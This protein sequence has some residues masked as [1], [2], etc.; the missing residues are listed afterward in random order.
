MVVK[1][2]SPMER[3]FRNILTGKVFSRL[4]IPFEELITTLNMD[5]AVRN[6][7]FQVNWGRKIDLRIN[8]INHSFGLQVGLKEEE[9]S[10]YSVQVRLYPCNG[11]EYLPASLVLSMLETNGN[12]F[13]QA[14]SREA[15]KWIQ[16]GLIG[17]LKEEFQIKI[18]LEE[19]S[20]IENFVI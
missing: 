20:I 5:L 7:R 13:E 6:N 9:E 15:D 1:Q 18:Q 12:V 4:W 8:L 16:V 14:K 11:Q 19:V 17:K 10:K 3:T 2:N